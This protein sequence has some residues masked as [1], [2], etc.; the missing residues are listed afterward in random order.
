MAAKWSSRWPCGGTIRFVPFR[1]QKP[2]E[3]RSNTRET[4]AIYAAIYWMAG[5]EPRTIAHFWPRNSMLGSQTIQMDPNRAETSYCRVWVSENRVR[6]VSTAELIILF[7]IK[8]AIHW[9]TAWYS[10]VSGSLSDSQWKKPW[11]LAEVGI[12]TA[13]KPDTE[14]C[15]SSPAVQW[16]FPWPRHGNWW[17][18][19]GIYPE[20]M[21]IGCHWYKYV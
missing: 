4:V 14:I 16:S 3:R 17:L 15:W 21:A 8:L 5:L 10:P 9:G 2:A 13:V 19:E 11:G 12:Q 18:S 1:S 20:N 6:I 7:P